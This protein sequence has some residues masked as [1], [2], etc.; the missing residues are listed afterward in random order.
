[1]DDKEELRFRSCAVDMM[2]EEG[3]TEQKDGNFGQ[4]ERAMGGI[5]IMAPSGFGEADSWGGV[6]NDPSDLGFLGNFG[7]MVGLEKPGLSKDVSK[8]LGGFEDFLSGS[9]S[10]ATQDN[11]KSTS[12]DS[13]FSMGDFGIIA[14]STSSSETT[15]PRE[16]KPMP[17]HIEKYSS[18]FSTFSSAELLA[19]IDRVFQQESNLDYEF[20]IHKNKFSGVVREGS[21][22]VTKFWFKLKMYK[23]ANPK[24]VLVEMQRRGGCVIGFNFFFQ[25]LVGKLEAFILRRGCVAQGVD[26][27]LQG[28]IANCQANCKEQ[29][30][31]PEANADFGIT[32]VNEIG[33][34]AATSEGL[35]FQ[36]CTNGAL[37][38]FLSHDNLDRSLIEALCSDST[39]L[40]RALESN[41]ESGDDI[42]VD[43]TCVLLSNICQEEGLRDDVVSNLL[44]AIFNKLASPTCIDTLY[45]KRHLM[46]ALATLSS[47]HSSK[48]TSQPGFEKHKLVLQQLYS[49]TERQDNISQNDNEFKQ[50]LHTTLRQVGIH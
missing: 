34:A 19:E 33:I 32:D 20:N 6:E 25:R 29:K 36:R 26:T 15:Q 13:R 50:N 10:S 22:D 41:L 46:K 17:L 48:I 14:D 28:W 3:E 16:L 47:S 8:N 12:W 21:S 18:F 31:C 42:L 38:Q 4:P 5:D 7:D 40:I 35:S 27:G 24:E 30:K 2:F 9:S 37:S 39:D 44:T 49:D 1:M 45:G 23:C 11:N 43:D